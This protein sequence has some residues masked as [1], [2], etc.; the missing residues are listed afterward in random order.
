MAANLEHALEVGPRVP[1]HPVATTPEQRLL[2]RELSWLDFNGRVLALADQ[3]STPLLERAKFLAIFS[4]NLDEFFQVRVAG[5]KDQV[6]AG[7]GREGGDGLAPTDQLDAIRARVEELTA[8]QSRI[9]LEDVAPR[10]ADE[11][12]RFS[13]WDELDVDDCEHLVEVF[14]NQIFPVLTPLSVDPGHPFP[15]ISNLSLNLAVLVRDPSSLERR[16]ARVKVPNL[17]P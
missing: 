10:L 12:I 15:Y 2:N 7:F 8:H 6:A 13:N 16:F 11:G 9:F 3:T 14:E 4:Q 17:L 1:F 5:L